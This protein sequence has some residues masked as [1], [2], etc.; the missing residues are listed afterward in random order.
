MSIAE[1]PEFD[2]LLVPGG[3]GQQQL[4]NDEEVLSLIRSH[5]AAGRLVFSVCTGALLCGG[6]GILRGRQATT[7]WAAWNLLPYYAAKP[8]R[9]RVVVDG[10]LVTA[11]GVTAG[12]DAALVVASLLRGDATAQEIQLSIQY[13]PNPVFH[14]GTPETAP[15]EVLQAFNESYASIAASREAEARRFAATD[16]LGK[17]PRSER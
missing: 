13:A 15:A 12:L 1:A 14:S 9:S 10:N 4:M 6:A 17:D 5:F 8:I 3:Y 11:A 16:D 7:H 2:V